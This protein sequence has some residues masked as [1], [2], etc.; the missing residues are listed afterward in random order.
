MFLVNQKLDSLRE[1]FERTKDDFDEDKIKM[2]KEI[3][4]IKNMK[5]RISKCFK[6]VRKHSNESDIESA[7]HQTAKLLEYS[8]GGTREPTRVP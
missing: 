7:R 6:K 1:E 8:R 2:I 4:S 5:S 3:N